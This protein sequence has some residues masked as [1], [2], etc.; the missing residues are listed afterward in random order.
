MRYIALDFETANSSP[1]SACSVGISVFEDQQLIDSNAYLLKPPAEFGA[2]HW[3]NTRVHG[4][5][6]SMV[7]DAPSF[8]IVWAQIKHLFE[9]SILVCH[10]ATFDT[11][12]LCKTLNHYQLPLPHCKY[13]CTVKIA[14]KVWPD[15]DN[16]KLDT[17]SAALQI[18]LNHHEACSDA[19]ASG[20]I[21]QAAMSQLQCKNAAELA[22]QLQMRLGVISPEQ[23]LSCSTAKKFSQNRC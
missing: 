5:K 7:A 19:L 18:P 22:D 23:C 3:Y 14:Q 12:V 21:L 16:H 10:N 13:I 11:S 15:L 6:R 4:I 17:V 8:A 1:C 9:D 20:R 2:F